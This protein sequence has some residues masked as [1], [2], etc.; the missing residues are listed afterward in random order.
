LDL[1][2]ADSLC[3]FVPKGVAHGFLTRSDRSLVVYLTTSVHAP[4]FDRGVHWASLD[5]TWPVGRP[6]VSERD[7]S[8]PALAAFEPLRLGPGGE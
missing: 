4:E 3:V 7:E 6:I 2:D 1:G 5:F 8:L